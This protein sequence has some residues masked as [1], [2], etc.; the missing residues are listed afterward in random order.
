[1]GAQALATAAESARIRSTQVAF[2]E[3]VL[4]SSSTPTP[5]FTPT[6]TPTH[7]PTP[8]PTP[9]PTIVAADQVGFQYFQ[10]QPSQPVFTHRLAF[11]PGIN[12]LLIQ[13]ANNLASDSVRALP[14]NIYLQPETVVDLNYVLDSPG[15]E[16][17][18]ALLYPEG[19]L[20]ANTGD[21]L[22]GGLEV[23][24]QQDAG[25][26]FHAQT[27]CVAVKQI[28]ADMTRPDDTD[29]VA[30]TCFTGQQNDC[31][32]QL[33]GQDPIQ[34]PIGARVLLDVEKKEQVEAGPLIYEE[35]KTYFDTV[36]TL[37]GSFDQAQCLNAA[38]DTDGDRVYYPHDQCS[39]QA[40]TD[41]TGGCPDADR[42]TVP[43]AQ[44]QCPDTAGPVESGGCPVSTATPFPDS[45]GDGLNDAVDQCPL[46]AGAAD[47]YGCPAGVTATPE[48]RG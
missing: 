16:A 11:S 19:D 39:D 8:T 29:K 32:Y 12:Y 1:M 47:N 23:A 45:D 5:S 7:T 25:I 35:V 33:P 30:F 40:G 44:D 34:I 36:S 38:L 41:A 3:T 42:D 20:Y 48:G 17:L 31:Y 43:D 37:T 10:S 22:N 46:E 14:A 4:R 28:P 24:L 6:G 26:R 27:A 18:Q 21:F 9:R 13:G 2:R 15:R